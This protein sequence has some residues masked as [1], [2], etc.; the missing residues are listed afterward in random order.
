MIGWVLLALTWWWMFTYVWGTE[1]SCE[2][3]PEPVCAVV[4][5]PEN[6][7][8]VKTLE[9]NLCLTNTGETIVWKTIE[10][11]KTD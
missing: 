6:K 4:P 2:D 8:V 11:I 7:F 5:E 1:V 3:R 9:K 10:S